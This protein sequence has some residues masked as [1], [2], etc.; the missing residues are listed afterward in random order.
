MRY[1]TKAFLCLAVIAV[2]LPLSGCNK[3][4]KGDQGIQGLQG[5]QGIQ[6]LRGVRGIQG[7]EGPSGDPAFAMGGFVAKSDNNFCIDNI[8]GMNCD[9]RTVIV[10]SIADG[11][12]LRIDI[13][14]ATE[15]YF[16]TIAKGVSGSE[17]PGHEVN[18]TVTYEPGGGDNT[19]TISTQEPVYNTIH[20]TSFSQGYYMKATLL[21][22]SLLAIELNKSPAGE[23]SVWAV[24][25]ESQGILV[26]VIF[27][28]TMDDQHG[29][30]AVDI[31]NIGDFRANYLIV[32]EG[33][34]K[35]IN[36]VTPKSVL[37]D[38][39]ESA[40]VDFELEANEPFVSGDYCTVKLISPSGK[41]YDSI[42]VLP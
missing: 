6:G 31:Q 23:T 28:T 14:N 4:D 19:F 25:T 38:P 15:I 32:L 42:D 30:I 26:E 37:L 39:S 10:S 17:N 11:Q 36:P 8:D 35:E 9:E 13:A 12:E 29:A 40:H 1:S 41:L 18:F 27:T 21:S 7:P 2:I 34:S 33:C 3:R 16:V 5:D 24:E 22:T 20:D